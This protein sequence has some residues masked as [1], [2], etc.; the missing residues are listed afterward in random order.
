M[1]VSQTSAQESTQ[2][3]PPQHLPRPCPSSGCYILT[4]LGCCHP[5]VSVCYGCQ[6]PLKVNGQNTLPPLD[7]V[8]ITQM[9]REFFKDGKKMSRMGNVYFHANMHCLRSRLPFFHSTLLQLQPGLYAF[10]LPT[11]KHAINLNFG[12]QL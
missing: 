12:L 9:R 8:V 2:P 11:H 5:G 10:L 7:L 4:R 3:P 6:Q 1:Q